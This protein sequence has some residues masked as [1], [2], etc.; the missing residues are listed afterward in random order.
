MKR[1]LMRAV[2]I[3]VS[4]AILL[5]FAWLVYGDREPFLHDFMTYHDVKSFG[6]IF[7]APVW[8]FHGYPETRYWLTVGRDARQVRPDPGW[9]YYP[10]H[11]NGPT[12]MTK[13]TGGAN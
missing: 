12:P 13:P 8:V 9:N 5:P 4:A 6:R 7:T 11:T 10:P 1:Y 2:I 3:V